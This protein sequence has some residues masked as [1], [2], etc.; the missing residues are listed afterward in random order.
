MIKI[1]VEGAEVMVLEGSLR[2]LSTYFPS[3]IMEIHGPAN[4]EKTWDMI[5]SLNYSWLRLA[6]EGRSAVSTKK[7]LVSY[8]SKDFWTH[9]FLLT[10]AQTVA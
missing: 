7:E 3:I 6:D 1:D 10:K 8:F 9:H 2:T 4:A 5:Q